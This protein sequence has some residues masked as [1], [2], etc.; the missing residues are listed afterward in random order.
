MMI[1]DWFLLARN[2]FAAQRVPLLKPGLTGHKINSGNGSDSIKNA[3][4]YFKS[5]SFLG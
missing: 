1:D 2:Y 3:H 4:S 5:T